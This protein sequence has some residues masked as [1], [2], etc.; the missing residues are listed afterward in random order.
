MATLKLKIEGGKFV[1][2]NG[3]YFEEFSEDGLKAVGNGWEVTI[4]PATKN[5]SGRV[6]AHCERKYSDGPAVCHRE[7]RLEDGLLGLAGGNVYNRYVYFRKASFQAFLD[8]FGITAVK[9]EDPN[10]NFSGFSAYSGAGY[11]NQSV[12]T[13]GK[14]SWSYEDEPGSR[15]YFEAPG[16][17]PNLYRGK[18]THRVTGATWAIV[19]RRENYRDNHNYARILYT[20]V[21]DVTSLGPELRQHKERAEKIARVKKLL[22]GK[23]YF[24]TAHEMRNVIEELIGEF[25]VTPAEQAGVVTREPYSPFWNKLVYNGV[26]FTI[27]RPREIEGRYGSLDAV[28]ERIDYHAQLGADDKLRLYANRDLIAEIAV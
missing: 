19:E 17:N 22:D 25:P 10:Q 4:R 15:E 27:E 26:H 28:G 8:E 9:R 7:F 14:L 1:G 11:A 23:K 24:T 5:R 13:D 21:K 3:C 2:H 16:N 20:Q 12:E 18:E 6:I